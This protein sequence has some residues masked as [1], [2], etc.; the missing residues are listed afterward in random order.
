[1]RE[2]DRV[3]RVRFAIRV[4]LGTWQLAVLNRRGQRGLNGRRVDLRLGADRVGADRE[5]ATERPP[6]DRLVGSRGEGVV[7]YSDSQSRYDE[8]VTPL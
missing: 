2:K 3:Q 5:H 7:L 1:M 4:K 6:T 8:L